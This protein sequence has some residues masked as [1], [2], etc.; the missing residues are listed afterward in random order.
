MS[1][2]R[3]GVCEAKEG[4]GEGEGKGGAMTSSE[5]VD[6]DFHPDQVFFDLH[7]AMVDSRYYLTHC[8]LLMN[9]NEATEQ[10]MNE[11]AKNCSQAA[12][13]LLYLRALIHT[14]GGPSVT[15]RVY[16]LVDKLRDYHDCFQ[17]RLHRQQ[18]YRLYRKVMDMGSASASSCRSRYK[19]PLVVDADNF[20]ALLKKI[21]SEEQ[22][23]YRS[24]PKYILRSC[25][26]L[27]DL[28]ND[29]RK[30]VLQAMRV[31]RDNNY[32]LDLLDM[33]L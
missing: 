27:K 11:A 14:Y 30:G 22:K 2:V 23:L 24:T 12:T 33:R 21:G 7:R 13:Y 25:P 29:W 28:H 5:H 31:T 3:E 10:D 18:C 4:E 6:P 20:V 32:P 19:F 9:A 26:Y 15:Q 1:S 16:K 8:L 17:Y